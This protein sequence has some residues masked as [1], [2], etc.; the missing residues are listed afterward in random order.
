M[1]AFNDKILPKGGIDLS[2]PGVVLPSSVVSS[3]GA[4]INLV[5]VADGKGGYT[6]AAGSTVG[7]IHVVSG[8]PPN[9]LGAVGDFAYR[10]DTKEL[11]GPKF[12]EKGAIGAFPTSEERDKF[13]REPENP[14]N[15][16]GAWLGPFYNPGGTLGTALL[17]TSPGHVS[18]SSSGG[19]SAYNGTFTDCECF[20]TV[21]GFGSS[22]AVFTRV[23]AEPGLAWTNGYRA[24][25]EAG[26]VRLYSFSGTS[27][28]SLSVS[29]PTGDLIGLRSVGTAHTIFHRSGGEEIALFSATDASATTGKIGVALGGASDIITGFG[30][31]E[32]VRSEVAEWPTTPT[33]PSPAVYVQD[34]APTPVKGTEYVWFE[35]DGNGTLIDIV[36]GKA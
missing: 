13:L 17:L 7:V 35:M 11:V 3:S 21:G 36:S 24:K 4:A 34:A 9:S 10:T 28:G 29:I 22:I 12:I 19:S 6:W 5:P 23:S 32:I 18:A 33:I 16:A 15:H 8:A 30:G 25:F 20:A 14:L 27:L 31:G 1:P 2:G 26:F